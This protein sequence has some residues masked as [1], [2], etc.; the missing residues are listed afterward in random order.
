MHTWKIT[1]G[2][3]AYMTAASLLLTGCAGGA[4]GT[5]EAG[6]SSAQNTSADGD[7]QGRSGDNKEEKQSNGEAGSDAD[8]ETAD[9]ADGKSDTAVSKSDTADGK[10]SSADAAAPHFLKTTQYNGVY[11]KDGYT[12]LIDNTYDQL[13]LADYA[14]PDTGEVPEENTALQS[15]LDTV[16]KK[17]KKNSED[18]NAQNSNV[19]DVKQQMG[20]NF[21]P[22][23][24]SDTLGIVRVDER[25]LVISRNSYQ[26]ADGAHGYGAT[27]MYSFNGTSGKALTLADVLKDTDAQDVTDAILKAI[28]SQVGSDQKGGIFEDTLEQT[29]LDMVSCTAGVTGAESSNVQAAPLVWYPGDD[30]VHVI[31]NQYDIAAYAAGQ[32]EVTLKPADFPDLVK[33][34]WFSGDGSSDNADE[35]LEILPAQTEVDGKPLS[36]SENYDADAMTI[37]SLT[38]QYAG[39]S[40]TY[41]TYSY[42]NTYYYVRVDGHPYLY[43]NGRMDDDYQ[44][45]DV[46]DLD[47]DAMPLQQTDCGLYGNVLTD[48]GCMYLESRTNLMSTMMTVRAYSASENGVPEA[49][50]Q[51]YLA[52]PSDNIKF[53][54]KQYAKLNVLDASGSKG[55]S[56]LGSNQ[57]VMEQFKKGTTMVPYRTDGDHIMDCITSDGRYVRF[58]VDTQSV[59]QVLDGTYKLDELLDGTLFVG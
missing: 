31:F 47:D 38:V 2:I 25:A 32:I 42:G 51:Y 45:L 49:K 46:I 19:S 1:T 39:R 43:I 27:F 15:A 59:P 9:E 33:S 35:V 18:F 21:Q 24:N 13:S 58:D 23:T 5:G 11:E 16:N 28:D 44:E 54:L 20:E 36:I 34:S 53:T 8:T 40:K 57:T 14:D 55:T 12:E 30:G 10:A 6:K 29:V 22:Y 17:L 50:S 56:A 26:D 4:Q 48:P 3:I 41:D 52:L 37:S 7:A